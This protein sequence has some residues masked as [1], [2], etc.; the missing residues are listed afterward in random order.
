MFHVNLDYQSP[1]AIVRRSRVTQA[2]TFTGVTTGVAV[3]YVGQ[4][5]ERYTIGEQ[6]LLLDAGEFLLLPAGTAFRAEP[7][8]TGQA[9]VGVCIDFLA[10][11]PES[12]GFEFLYGG[13]FR[14]GDTGLTQ[15]ANWPGLPG[16]PANTRF[17]SLRE[18]VETFL[19][20][21][22]DLGTSLLPVANQ[23]VTR[24]E[25]SKRLLTTRTYLEH[26]FA[27]NLSLTDLSRIAGLSKYHFS[28]LFKRAFGVSP[29]KMQTM[30][31]M[32][33]AANMIQQEDTTLTSIA[34]TVGYTDLPGFSRHF[35]AHFGVPP[36][37]WVK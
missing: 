4:G 15:L 7:G 10:E 32:E 8:I 3:K 13:T 12:T 29:L 1:E 26:H 5:Q 14:V 11:L 18:E 17:V 22:A 25:L 28:R 6:R 23:A 31:R 30:L 16:N 33:A 27:D 2:A 20:T 9:T 21:A 36:S 35:R 24:R 19:Q 34:H 37:R